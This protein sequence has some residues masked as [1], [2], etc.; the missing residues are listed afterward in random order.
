MYFFFVCFLQHFIFYAAKKAKQ[1]LKAT[2]RL[3][4]SFIVVFRKYNHV[5]HARKYEQSMN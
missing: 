2:R 5:L 4:A 3:F 1:L